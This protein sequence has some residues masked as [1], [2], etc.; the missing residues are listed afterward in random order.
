MRSFSHS[1]N[2]RFQGLNVKPV[3]VRTPYWLKRTCGR[4]LCDIIVKPNGIHYVVRAFLSNPSTAGSSPP[5]FDWALCEGVAKV[6]ALCP[7]L[8]FTK[9]QYIKA[10][11]PQ[12]RN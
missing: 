6:I 7:H 10:L 3:L 12:V 9:E 4:L 8:V 5:S 1:G 11:A 2:S